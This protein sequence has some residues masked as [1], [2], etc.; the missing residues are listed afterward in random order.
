MLI[1]RNSMLRKLTD[2]QRRERLLNLQI[3]LNDEAEV[4]RILD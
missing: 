1:H 3:V 2:A 4:S